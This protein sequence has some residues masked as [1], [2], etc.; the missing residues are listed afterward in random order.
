MNVMAFDVWRTLKVATSELRV[1]SGKQ[2]VRFLVYI[3]HTICIT[4]MIVA[5]AVI[6]DS[7]STPIPK[8]YQPGFGM[9]NKCWF[10]RRKSLIVFFAAPIGVV[11]FLNLLFFVLTARLISNSPPLY[12]MRL[13]NSQQRQKRNFKLYIRL[14][15]LMGL[16]WISSFIAT[17]V[18]HVFLWYIFVLLNSLQGLFIFICFSCNAKVYTF[19]KSRYFRKKSH[20]ISSNLTASSKP[21][22]SQ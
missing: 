3:L 10:N 22:S 20:T 18:D 7:S 11:L 19:I 2:K 14:S 17:F 13:A 15:L 6:S 1:V 21:Y 8:E 5:C 4:S 16:S 12:S 9:H